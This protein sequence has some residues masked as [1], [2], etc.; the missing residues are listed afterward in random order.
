MSSDAAE[1]FIAGTAATACCRSDGSTYPEAKN[2]QSMREQGHHSSF[3]RR[4][5][6]FPSVGNGE[7]IGRVAQPDLLPRVPSRLNNGN[8][9]INRLCCPS[10]RWQCLKA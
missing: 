7:P 1:I 2:E 5:A 9:F 10:A 4:L 6:A 8:Q 3:S